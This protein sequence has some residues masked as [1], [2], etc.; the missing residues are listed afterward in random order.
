MDKYIYDESNGL[1]YELQGDY[2]IPCLTLS[3]EEQKPIGI[4]RQRHKCYLKE[5]KKATYT[6]FLTSGKLSA[7]LADIDEQAEEMFSQLIKQIAENQGITEQ[8]KTEKSS[9]LGWTDE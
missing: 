8:M 9:V 5:Y 4:W 3:A 2:Y 1:Q 7:Y 6:I